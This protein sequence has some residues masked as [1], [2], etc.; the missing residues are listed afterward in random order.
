MTQPSSLAER[1]PEPQA[2]CNPITRSAIFIVATLAPGAAA[3][4]TVRD[5]CTDIAAL[6]RSVGKRVP[7][8]N[9]SCVCG[10]GSSAWDRLFGG[11]HP[12][13]LHPFIEVGV[14]GRRAPSTP[15]D[16]LLH[17]RAEQMDLCFE[18]ATQLL[19]PLGDSIK[20]VDE[21]QGFRYFDMRSMVGFV[22]GTENPEGREAVDFTLVG[23]EDPQFC[24]GSYVLV[25]KYLHNM[26]A[27]N[28]LTVEA[29][30]RII[31][32]TKLSDIEL[33]DAVKP[34]CSHSSLTTLE[35]NG[36]EVKILRDNMPFGRPGAG[37]FGTYF[38]GYA[39]S[40][41][42]VEQMLEN[43]FVGRP[44]GNYDRLL[45]FSTAVTGGLFFVPSADLLEDL[46]ERAPTGL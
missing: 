8:G 15:G 10:F 44:A 37:E 4:Q 25:Q 3:A 28:E 39:R 1:K 12:A 36:E 18:L 27:W 5:W 7:G 17:I 9:L 16:L 11:P 23:D 45:D 32:R 38:I 35:E 20:V 46:A 21:V 29:Q 40:P 43:M 6:T 34:S 26:T 41:R 14:E 33:D 24:N 31:G 13:S 19:K 2:I 30:E 42:P 22:D